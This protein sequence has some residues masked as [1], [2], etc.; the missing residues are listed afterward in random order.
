MTPNETELRT[1]PAH[2]VFSL[3]EQ[4]DFRYSIIRSALEKDKNGL[5]RLATGK[6]QIRGFRHLNRAPNVMI[7][8]VLSEE[9]NISEEL[10][11]KLLEHWLDE[12]AD[13]RE[14][15]A[16]KLRELG[17]EPQVTPFDDTGEIGWRSM[18]RE[19]AQSQFDGEFLPDEDKN[20]VMLMSLLLGW[21]GTEEQ[22]PEEEAVET[23]PEQVEKRTAKEPAKA[24]TP[25]AEKK[26]AKKAEKTK[27]EKA[28]V[29]KPVAKESESVKKAPPQKKKKEA[30]AEKAPAAAPVVKKAGKAEPKKS[31]A[32]PAAKKKP[33][34]QAPAGKTPEQKPS[35]AKKSPPKKGK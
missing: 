12:H 4:R 15:V 35:P 6:H 20:G 33:A 18:S 11:R 21:F 2:A 24:V 10:A 8:P 19:H 27:E 1:H 22:E 7:V 5:C 23:L 29:K 3:I 26:E 31:E 25:I 28:A 17:Y 9:A 14:K 13:L 32:E 34:K 16:S 30:A